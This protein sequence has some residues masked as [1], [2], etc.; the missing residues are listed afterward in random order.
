VL[1]AVQQGVAFQISQ[2][3]CECADHPAGS[4]EH[5][6]DSNTHSNKMS[7]QHQPV[8]KVINEYVPWIAA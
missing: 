4:E 2:Q 7:S 1:E 3:Q 6:N 8:A 5:S